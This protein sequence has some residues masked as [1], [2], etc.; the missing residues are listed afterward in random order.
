MGIEVAHTVPGMGV[1]EYGILE[2]ELDAMRAIESRL[3]VMQRYGGDIEWLEVP[4]PT[5]DRIGVVFNTLDEELGIVALNRTATVVRPTSVEAYRNERAAKVAQI[6]TKAFADP[7]AIDSLE[8]RYGKAD[9]GDEPNTGVGVATV[10]PL[11]SLAFIVAHRERD[12]LPP[13]SQ[14]VF[15]DAIEWRAFTAGIKSGEF[16]WPK[17]GDAG[18]FSDMTRRQ[19]A[20]YRVNSRASML[21]FG[22]IQEHEGYLTYPIDEA[23]AGR[24]ASRAATGWR[25]SQHTGFV[26]RDFLSH[27]DK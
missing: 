3:A 19:L 26:L 24:W 2:R 16:N 22:G 10:G 6:F 17:G 8:W 27:V 14:W 7:V 18:H 21:K 23:L 13:P 4:E 12:G 11:D 9:E 25:F 20:H 5:G 15:Y 1:Q